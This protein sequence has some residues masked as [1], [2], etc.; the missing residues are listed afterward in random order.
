MKNSLLSFLFILYSWSAL[1]QS[2]HKS[3]LDMINYVVNQLDKKI[4][5]D[6]SNSNEIAS[7]YKLKADSNFVE[8]KNI[9]KDYYVGGSY[10]FLNDSL[11]SASFDSFYDSLVTI[12][13]IKNDADGIHLLLSKNYGLPTDNYDQTT[14]WNIKHYS[15][16]FTIYD[17]G[18]GVYIRSLNREFPSYD[19][20]GNCAGIVGDFFTLDEDL[21]SLLLANLKSEDI[22][23]GYTTKDEIVAIYGD[24]VMYNRDFEGIRLS[25]SFTYKG[26]KLSSIRY[27]YFYVCE[28]AKVLLSQD[29]NDIKTKIESVLGTA[30]VS[31]SGDFQTYDWTLKGYKITQS[32]FGDGYALSINK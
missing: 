29:K 9:F 26:D 28:G 5:I 13:K 14:T 16:D 23:I 10:L 1:A 25:A 6:K 11:I 3:G 18:W 30:T 20:T 21:T 22:A 8:I 24:S 31:G 12:E 2:E 32:N 7:L 15:I 19:S 27:D 4:I 17:N